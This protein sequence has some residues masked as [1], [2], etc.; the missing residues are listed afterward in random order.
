ME[1]HRGTAAS[2]MSGWPEIDRATVPGTTEVGVMF[3]GS[4]ED[5]SD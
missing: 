4:A 3:A 2:D 1:I 5:L